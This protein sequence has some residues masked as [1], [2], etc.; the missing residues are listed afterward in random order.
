MS[1]YA[2]TKA[3]QGQGGDWMRTTITPRERERERERER[4]RERFLSEDNDCEVRE[5][6]K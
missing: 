3:R 4:Q 2:S 6:V 5:W 1:S